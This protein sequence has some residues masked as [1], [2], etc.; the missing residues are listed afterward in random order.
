VGKLP[1]YLPESPQTEY[2]VAKVLVTDSLAPQGFEILQRAPG[3]EV[4]T[5]R[6]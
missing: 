6:G 5:R 3:I 1:H 4:S 2:A